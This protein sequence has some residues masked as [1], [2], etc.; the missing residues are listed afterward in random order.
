MARSVIKFNISDIFLEGQNSQNERIALINSPLFGAVANLYNRSEKKIRVGHIELGQ[1]THGVHTFVK[2]VNIV[3]SYGYPVATVGSN[4]AAYDSVFFSVCPS[5][6]SHS[7]R[8]ST[9][10]PKYLQNKLGLK[11]EHDAA[12]SFDFYLRQAE[13]FLPEH[14]RSI[15]DNLIDRL[16]GRANV[17]AP[18]CKVG[19][20]LAHFLALCVK[21]EITQSEIPYEYRTQ[22]DNN[23]KEY[24]SNRTKFMDAISQVSEFCSGEKWI[25]MNK[26]NKGVI[27]GAIDTK[28]S[29]AALDVY[30]MGDCLPSATLGKYDYC[31]ESVALKWYPSHEAIPDDLR[32]Q[33]ELSL[34]MLKAHRD[35]SEM[36]PSVGGTW[37]E[38]GCHAEI[39]GL[40]GEAV[41]VLAK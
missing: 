16:S 35:S 20:D 7:T 26:I 11:S 23:F 25:Y 9:S 12:T 4:N 1:Q 32:Q 34:V 18:R 39:F 33:V 17:H 24:T 19:N 2:K 8:L 21:G 3:T 37:L 36:L 40:D 22:L 27:L 30:K 6:T 41:Y 28:P 14:F 10:K 15:I 31:K 38:M 5:P 29:V 13:H